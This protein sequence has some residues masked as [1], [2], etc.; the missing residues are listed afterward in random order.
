MAG[1]DGCYWVLIGW[2]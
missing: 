1:I 2:L